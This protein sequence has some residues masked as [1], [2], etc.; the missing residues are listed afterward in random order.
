VDSVGVVVVDIFAEK[1]LQV[2]L[3]H[4]DHV[5]QQLVA[6][7]AERRKSPTIPGRTGIENRRPYAPSETNR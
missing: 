1:T 6:S 5:I 7:A 4:D 2:L 3:V